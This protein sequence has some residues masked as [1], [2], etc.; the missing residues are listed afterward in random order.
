MQCHCAFC[1]SFATDGS[2]DRLIVIL[3]RK[4][5]RTR[6]FMETF[7]NAQQDF[8]EVAL[9]KKHPQ[10]QIS[11]WMPNLPHLPYSKLAGG[12]LLQ[13]SRAVYLFAGIL[14]ARDIRSVQVKPKYGTEA[15][16][17]AHC[18]YIGR[19][20]NGNKVLQRMSSKRGRR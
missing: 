4:K 1:L 5:S 2:I 6:L 11:A 20:N 10:P 13:K 18:T 15:V 19:Y 14:P 7:E 8:S 12:C 3:V 17:I 16:H 9:E